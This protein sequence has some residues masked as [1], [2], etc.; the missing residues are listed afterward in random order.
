MTDTPLTRR[1]A[2]ARAGPM[3]LANATVP[4]AG[5]VDTAVIGKVG[6]AADL[7]GV[8]L[9]VAL[10]NVVY[11]SFYFLRMG[12]TGLAAQADGAGDGGEVARALTRALMLAALFGAVVILA[13]TPIAALGFAVLQGE[14]DVEAQGALYFL[15]RSWGAPGAFAIFAVTGWLI[16][17]G[18]T[19]ATLA[20]HVMFSLVNIVLDLWFVLGLGWGVEGVGRATAIAEWSGA[21]LVAA[22]IAGPLVRTVRG[23]RGVLARDA[24]WAPAAWRRLFAVNVDLMVRTWSLVIGFTW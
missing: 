3:I 16:G 8:A 13:R 17:L 9:G 23:A 4:L 12:T 5:V 22:L 10:F 2:L 1:S 7:G 20:V 14:R 24:L 6:T 15:A 18:R 21:A 19:G 11:W